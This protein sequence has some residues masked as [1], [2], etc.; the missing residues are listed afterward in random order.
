[1]SQVKQQQRKISF[2]WQWNWK[3]LLFAAFFLPV[4]VSLAFWQMDRAE[5]KRQLLDMYNQRG[6]AQPVPLS[7]LSS[8]DDRTYIRVIV[9]GQYD[10]RS[11]LLLDNRVRRGRAGYEV[12]NPFQTINGQWLLVNRGWVPAGF[13]RRIL[14]KISEV[15]GEVVLAGYLYRSPGKQIMLGAD[16]WAE[17]EGPK[18][19]QNA[20]PEKVSEKLGLGFYSYQLRLGADAIGAYETGWAIVNIQPSKHTGYVFQWSALTLALIIL[21]IFA[22]SNL[23]AVIGSKRTKVDSNKPEQM[24]D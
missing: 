19:I 15:S 14:P 4:T 17:G 12:I 5:E 13:D 9:K 6:V 7:E 21:A 11:P 20:A 18:V 1:M 3:I 10:N 23:G 24:N 16:L 2:Q 8:N 22:N